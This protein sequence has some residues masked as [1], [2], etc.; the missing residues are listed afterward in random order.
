MSY[1]KAIGPG[2]MI[3][4]GI[5]ALVVATLGVGIFLFRGPRDSRPTADSIGQE[6]ESRSA[7]S[8]ES[9]LFRVS[10]EARRNLA[11]QVRPA[12]PQTFQRRI[13]LPGQVVDR[14]GVSDRSV[15]APWAGKV[16]G[17]SAFPGLAIPPGTPLFSLRLIGDSLHESQLELYRASK[18]I[19]IARKQKQRLGELAASGTVPGS[20]MIEL[21]NGIERMAVQVEACR[22]NLLAHGFSAEQIRAATGGEFVTE[23]TVHAPGETVEDASSG[24]APAAGDAV[25]FAY[26]MHRL[27]VTPGQQVEAGT[28]L[29]T[30]AD[31]R[32]LMIEGRGFRKDLPAIQQTALSQLPV[33]VVFD[34]G[35]EVAWPVP[36]TGFTIEHVANSVDPDS[37]TFAFYLPLQNQSR[38]FIQGGKPR[39]LW[40]FRPGDRV[41]LMV[42]SGVFEDVFVL[43]IGAVVREEGEAYVFRQN[44]DLFER[45]GV[46]ILSE[47]SQAVILA[48]DGKIRRNAYLA[49]NQA[50]ALN[51]ILKAQKSAGLPA[52]FHVHADG[53]VHAAHGE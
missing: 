18:E 2:R 42:A 26:E 8:G 6:V 51:R 13:E 7:G 9:G 52:N 39:L 28:V 41:R 20:R 45:I 10:A 14:P 37:R 33:E 53:T 11:L 29:C 25:S 38:S 23:A 17:I 1:V 32:S 36:M 19:E 47:D 48:N 22:Q 15:V 5:A 40:R 31:H 44:G 30:L 46:H 34:A 27:A 24:P 12:V 21:D 16:I 49:Q 35:S 4:Y 43:P 50:S 3:R